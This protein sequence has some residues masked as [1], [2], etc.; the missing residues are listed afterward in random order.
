MNLKLLAFGQAAEIIQKH[1]WEENWVRDL[2]LLRKQLEEKHPGLKELN[3]I[4]SVNHQMVEGNV[5]LPP[6]AEIAIMP[7]FSGG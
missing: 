7:P 1:Q 4:F 3:Y 5:M 2:N 6:N